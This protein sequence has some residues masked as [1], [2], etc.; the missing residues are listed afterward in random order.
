[1]TNQPDVCRGVCSYFVEIKHSAITHGM[2]ASAADLST[3]SVCPAALRCLQGFNE[4]K[5]F[6]TVL[7]LW[8]KY[9]V[10]ITHSR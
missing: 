6:H 8:I 7:Q 2:C 10:T 4:L 1:M 5:D 9:T 3:Y